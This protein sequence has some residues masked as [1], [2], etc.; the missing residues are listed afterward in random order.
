MALIP[1]DFSSVTSAGLASKPTLS[2]FPVIPSAFS[3][4]ATPSAFGSALPKKAFTP[5]C[6]A[7]ID[8]AT[9]SLSLVACCVYCT[10][11]SVMPG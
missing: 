5:R 2:T 9:L 1:P 7:R 6:A 8:R 11:S 3:A 10:G 4:S